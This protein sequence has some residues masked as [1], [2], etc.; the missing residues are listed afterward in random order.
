MT[1]DDGHVL[2]HY[3]YIYSTCHI[4]SVYIVNPCLMN[5]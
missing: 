4:L 5:V 2:A 3:Y 1:M